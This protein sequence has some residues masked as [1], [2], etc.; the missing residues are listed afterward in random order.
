MRPVRDNR[1]V[2]DVEGIR[3]SDA[4]V[5]MRRH[6]SGAERAIDM[7]WRLDPPVRVLQLWPSLACGGQAMTGD[8]CLSYVIDSFGRRTAQG[9]PW[10]PAK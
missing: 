4:V 5:E 8:G 9:R 1:H 10:W 3:Y 7:Q 6:P 2:A